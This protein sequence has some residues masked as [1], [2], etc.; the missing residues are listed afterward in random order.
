MKKTLFFIGCLF[1]AGLLGFLIMVQQK[2]PQILDLYKRQYAFPVMSYQSVNQPLGSGVILYHVRFGLLPVRHQVGQMLLRLEPNDTRIIMRDVAV[3]VSDTL[4]AKYGHQL[5]SHLNAYQ[6]ARDIFLKPLDTLAFLGIDTWRGDV[7]IS[8]KKE[9]KTARVRVAF[10]HKDRTQAVVQMTVAMTGQDDA[11]F[12][13][14][15][16]PI[17]NVDIQINDARLLQS[18]AVYAQSAEELSSAAAA[19]QPAQPFRWHK[20]YANP[21]A[22]VRSLLSF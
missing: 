5:P 6:P 12:G 17:E 1:F 22:S 4:R 16:A 11:L 7:A 19:V 18:F 20:T 15:N 10:G 3:F 14:L 13:F 8:V 9:N 21:G 2:S